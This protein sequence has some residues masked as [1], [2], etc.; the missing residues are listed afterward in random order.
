MVNLL[1]NQ[2]NNLRLEIDMS[3]YW[4]FFINNE[5]NADLIDYSML[6]KT[7]NTKCLSSF[8]DL[9]DKR[10][11][12]GREISSLPEYTWEYS[13]NTFPL[14][15]ENIGYTGVDNGFIQF[16]RDEINNEKFLEIYQNS[17]YEIPS[18]NRL[19]L[20]EVDGSSK[21]FSYSVEEEENRVKLNGGFYQGFF[22]TECNRYKVLPDSLNDGECWGFEFVVEKTD[23]ENKNETLNKKYPDNKGIFFYIGTRAENKWDNLYE[24]KV[25]EEGNYDFFGDF[26]DLDKTLKSNRESLL[27]PNPEMPVEWESE[28]MDDYLSFKY[29]DDDEYEL[30]DDGLEDYFYHT[31]KAITIDEDKTYTLINCW[32]KDSNCQSKKKNNITRQRINHSCG[33]GRKYIKIEEIDQPYQCND[34]YVS[35]CEVFDL[36]EDLETI[37]DG[38]DYLETEID[39]SNFQFKTNNGFDF[40]IKG[41]WYKDY[42]NPFLLYDRTC[43]GYTV[44]NY[45]TGD[46]VRY[47]GVKHKY[48]G[49]PFLYLNRTCTGYTASQLAME[50]ELIQDEYDVNADLYQNAFALRITDDG[51]IGYK[52]L[53]RD[54]DTENQYTIR[55][56]YSKEGIIKENKISVIHVR[57]KGFAKTMALEFYVN[58]KLVFLTDEMPKL[59][60]RK[61]NDLYEK[62]EGVPFNISLG[63]GTQGLI[64]TVLPDYMSDVNEVYPLERNFAGTF[65]GYLYAFRFY[66]CYLNFFDVLNNYKY[67]LENKQYL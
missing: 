50:E 62:Q 7:L 55:E 27:D 39:I 60:L 51:K 44:Q 65:I 63:G 16:K 23:F 36:I 31:H 12:N 49:N 33:C 21:R 8:I 14:T 13:N 9:K 1:N 40:K 11:I 35:R 6:G 52:F 2:F 45:R 10:C 22:E 3:E 37:E 58:G 5:P 42:T 18:D 17:K 41:Q 57:F 48:K 38:W 43:N 67:E 24:N 25:N 53:I 46:I 15:L 28:S 4:D 26:I 61:L 56:G 19:R 32:C 34:G 30:A 66:T 29:Y 54:C 64:E 47:V 59:N 20:F